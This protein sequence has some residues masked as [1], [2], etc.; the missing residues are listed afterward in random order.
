MSDVTKIIYEVRVGEFTHRYSLQGISW[1]ITREMCPIYTKDDDE[2][3]M[4]TRGKRGIA[5][6]LVS[7]VSIVLEEPVIG[8][9][10]ICFGDETITLRNVQ[11][12][13]EGDP[14]NCLVADTLMTWV[15]TEIESPRPLKEVVKVT[16]GRI[17]P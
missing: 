12:L 17:E 16:G 7:N 9:V 15:A 11:I 1:A 5:G 14:C 2:P 10:I 8:T 4:A 13:N 6:C 3:M